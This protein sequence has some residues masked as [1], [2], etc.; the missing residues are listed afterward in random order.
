MASRK[1]KSG[2][3]DTDP[4]HKEERKLLSFAE[5]ERAIEE[6][7]AEIEAG[8]PDEEVARMAGVSIRAVTRWRTKNE[9]RH[10]R[11]KARRAEIADARIAMNLLGEPLEDVLQRTQDTATRGEWEP[12]KYNLRRGVNYDKLCWQ[13][14]LMHVVLGLSLEEI[15]DAH[16]YTLKTVQDAFAI[17]EQF[18]KKKGQKCGRCNILVEPGVDYGCSGSCIRMK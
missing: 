2:V 18:L 4:Q 16:G 12:P 13:V 10:A 3:P 5:S 14:Y 6:Y 1:H 7:R 17:E 8:I 11:S 9:I 15:A